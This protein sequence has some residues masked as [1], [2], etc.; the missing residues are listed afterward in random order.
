MTSGMQGENKTMSEIVKVGYIRIVNCSSIFI[1]HD[2]GYFQDEGI[3]AELIPLIGGEKIM[4]A[5]QQNK[6]DIG[7]SNVASMI[8][9]FDDGAKFASIV[10]GAAQDATCPVHAIFVHA[11]SDIR[12]VAE[13]E[14][15]KIA[16]NTNRAIDEVMVPPLVMKYDADPSGIQFLPIPFPEM[17]TALKRGEVDAVVQIEPFVTI[18]NTDSD[19]RRISYNYIKLQPVTEISSMVA[20]QAWVET[21]PEL[22]HAFRRAIIK[23]AK[24]ANTHSQETRNVLRQYVPL[25]KNI[26][27]TLILPRFIEGSLNEGLLD[28]MILR[29]RQAGWL[30]SNFS[31]SNL[32]AKV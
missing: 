31:A 19:L 17:F 27:D 12:T 1:A 28:E 11:N 20:M 4:T 32:I 14:N 7:F 8:F 6:V 9:G 5:L 25:E 15:A 22:V 30:K 13:L 2:K 23:A 21:H 29:M 18:G 3:E 24:F 16:V 26:L 10:G